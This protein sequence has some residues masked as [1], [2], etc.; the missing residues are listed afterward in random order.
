MNK[1]GVAPI[2]ISRL[3]VHEVRVTGVDRDHSLPVKRIGAAEYRSPAERLSRTRRQG[4]SGA[5]EQHR[6]RLNGP[7]EASG[8]AIR[9]QQRPVMP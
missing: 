2:L 1:L 7:T 3:D 9:I 4:Q 5:I 6:R 8:D